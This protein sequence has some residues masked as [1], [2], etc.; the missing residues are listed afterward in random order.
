MIELLVR[1]VISMTVVMGVMALAAKFVR[2]RQGLAPGP[3]PVGSRRAGGAG[4][5]GTAGGS[6]ANLRGGPKPRRARPETPVHVVYR[7][8]LAKG[9]W[10]TLVEAAGKSFL[11]GVTEQSVTLL[12][13][14]PMAMSPGVASTGVASTGVA[15]T[16]VA[17][18]GVA[19]TGVGSTGVASTG[20]A[21]TGV[22]W[23]EAIGLAPAGGC[24]HDDLQV[25]G[26][27]AFLD[28][29]ASGGRPDS[30][31]K[32]TLDSLRERTVRR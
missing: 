11:V 28:D 25:G 26:M 23:P 31:W 17:S 18:T 19:S 2:W 24:E 29:A 8:A 27:P 7:R 16:G 21:S 14:L 9:A 12:A 4:G 32:L 22:A 5:A 20:V 6:L 30:A 10:V 13:E 1:L 3:R 15:S